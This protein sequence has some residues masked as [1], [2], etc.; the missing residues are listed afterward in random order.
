MP[1]K[2]EYKDF[3]L[4][5]LNGVGEITFKQMMGE[6]LL[7]LNG[8]L[9]GGIYDDRLLV[10]KT[11][12]N[13]CFGMPDALPYDGAKPMYSVDCIDDKEKLSDVILKTYEGLSK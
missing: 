6:Y 10:K 12:E 5:Q 2:K 8:L 3:V 4:G 1:T 11:A 13:S 7:Y 9:I